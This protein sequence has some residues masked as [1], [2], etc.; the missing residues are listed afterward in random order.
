MSLSPLSLSFSLYLS[1]TVSASL[2]LSLS[3]IPAGPLPLAALLKGKKGGTPADRPCSHP[4]RLAL[5]LGSSPSPSLHLL[6]LSH[7][8]THTHRVL[9]FAA[10]LLFSFSPSL[11]SLSFN[12][13]S[14]LR[15]NTP[16]RA[17]PLRGCRCTRRRSWS[18]R[19]SSSAATRASCTPSRRT[20][21]REEAR[22]GEGFKAQH[23]CNGLQGR[24]GAPPPVPLLSAAAPS[25]PEQR[26]G[27]CFRGSM[28]AG[29]GGG[30]QPGVA[31]LG[32]SRSLLRSWARAGSLA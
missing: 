29:G 18:G 4:H 28:G 6:S 14:N 27:L 2:S 23:C 17:L 10:A 24:L 20:T 22:A 25:L 9:S 11:L 7:T 31:R 21:V 19:T 12:A 8:H 26:C 30:V 13:P 5:S 15:N 1:L 32:H 3:L 16:Q